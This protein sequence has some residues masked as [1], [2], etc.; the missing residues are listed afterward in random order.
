MKADSTAGIGAPS[1]GRP[2][3]LMELEDRTLFSATPL[4]TA[5]VGTT[6]QNAN[7]SAN[8]QR[9]SPPPNNHGVD[10]VLIDNNLANSKQLAQAVLPGDKVWLYDSVHE[11]A[12]QV[13]SEVE[14]WAKSNGERIEDLAILSHGVGGGFELGN[15]WITARSLLQTSA[16]WQ[17]LGSVLA[18]RANIELFGCDVAAPGSTGQALINELANLTGAEVL[19][20]TNTTGAGGDWNL[21]AESAGAT[22][23]PASS[24]EGPFDYA[25]LEEYKST[26]AALQVTNTNDSGTGSFRQAILDADASSGPSTIVFDLSTSD[27]NYNSSTGVWTIS[28]ASALPLITQPITIDATTQPGYAGSPLVVLTGASAGSGANGINLAS[29]SD[30]STVKGLVI[31]GF[32]GVGIQVTSAN[33]TIQGDYIGTNAAGAAMVGNGS[34]GIEINSNNNLVG[35]TTAADR[36]IISGNFCG[37]FLLGNDNQIEGNYIG[38]DVTGTVALANPRE[39]IELYGGTGNVIGG[40]VA[41]AGN[42]ISGNGQFGVWEYGGGGVTADN[43]VIEGNLIGTDAAG[44]AALGNGSG[45]I[46]ITDGSGNTIGGTSVATR[47]VISG[48]IGCG[49]YLQTANA[50]DTLIEGNYIGVDA[51]GTTALANSSYG[52][53]VGPRATNNV[54]GGSAPG[55][56]NVIS[57]NLNAGVLFEVGSSGSIQGNYIGTNAAGTAPISGNGA[58]IYLATS[59][60]LVGG[61]AAGDGNLISGSN[62]NGVD[63][64]GAVQNDSILGNSISA[65]AG[66][67]IDLGNDGVTPNH[68]GIALLS[69]NGLQ[70]F[71]VLSNVQTTGVE[72]TFTGSL[73]S[74]ILTTYRIEL[75]SNS[76]GDPS[77]YG[78]GTTYLGSTSVTTNLVGN[79]NFTAALPVTI[80]A[81]EV[82]S[83]T[84]TADLGNGNYGGTSEF[85][86]D[87]VAI[88]NQ[89]PVNTVPSAQTVNGTATLVFS[90]GNGNQISIADSD[91]NGNPEQIALSVG[92]GTLTL[93]GTAGL[94]FTNG[95]NGSAAMTVQGTLANINAALNGLTYTAPSNLTNNSSDALNL[96][97]NDLGNS[98]VGGPQTASNTVNIT[99]NHLDITPV[100]TVPAA[101][102]VNGNATLV[103]SSGNGNQISVNDADAN[104]N[105]EQV[106]LSV[107][108]GTLTLNGTIGLTFT[109]GSNGSAMLTVQG[110]LANIN[111]ALSGLTYTPPPNLTNSSSD[112]LNVITNDLGNTGVGGPLSASGTVNIT[113]NHIDTAPVNTVPANQSTEQNV[114]LVFSG[115]N[116]NPISI[117]DK[118]AN[119]APEQMTLSATNGTLTL[120]GTSGLT[121]TGGANGGATMTFQ[122]TIANINNALNGLAFTPTADYAGAASLQVV[123][124]DLGNTGIGGPQ[125]ATNATNITINNATPTLTVPSPQLSM[126]VGLVF[127]STNGNPI[128]VGS[129]GGSVS[130]LQVTLTTT[131]GTVTLAGTSGLSFTSGNGLNNTATTFSGTIAAINAALNGMVFRASAVNDGLTVTATNVAAGNN[132][133]SV[134]ATVPIQQAPLIPPAP[135]PPNPTP[136]PLPP[137]PVVPGPIVPAPATPVV[138]PPVPPSTPSSN[139]EHP[140]TVLPTLPQAPA[141]M[142]TMRFTV[143]ASFTEFA[144]AQVSLRA[145][146]NMRNSRIFDGFA[147]STANVFWEDLDSVRDQLLSRM[148][149]H[150]FVI[151]SAL[152]VSTGLTVGYVMWMLRGGMLLSS[153]IAQ[154]PAWSLIDPLVVL[155]RADDWEDEKNRD[156][157]KES[158]EMIFDASASASPQNARMPA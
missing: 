69:P 152:T 27:P 112:T 73:S 63:V 156:E 58:G 129:S 93:S 99:L 154:I 76:T 78:Q 75:F 10:V 102:T 146:G 4:S 128:I 31:D 144:M 157:N 70:N 142:T 23:P 124:N 67:G 44:T 158:L 81:G 148:P 108:G 89:P 35:G 83:A 62:V 86:Q 137:H 90:G 92:S 88:G 52:I 126:N 46:E 20:S 153:L 1:R 94:T 18:A 125:I 77:G 60:I 7:A 151:G 48:N 12:S 136:A 49:V 104:G 56:G 34:Y 100:N 110:T 65:N 141:R 149:S 43:T 114:P 14:T 138:P 41:G 140:T 132:P 59:N 80:T 54:V 15:Q 21:E 39:G 155:S 111:N 24:V 116:G 143:E 139:I 134:T 6:N 147:S 64:V 150:A 33:N 38:V 28:P 66:L 82:I 55:Q 127:S 103:F 50:T 29:G 16:A 51:T 107:G 87:L 79:A 53:D 95:S 96:V 106:T 131:N 30:G 105:P 120:G 25:V 26:L 123:T 45:G 37:V 97:T 32:S 3:D 101:Q 74:S 8:L 145:G 115:A 36:N 19:A 57:G 109:A 22:S 113:I 47:N 42:V 5:A 40:A 72:T 91:S 11:S 9:P 71:P 133:P 135:S 119:G 117:A 130:T 122:G 68:I 13:L 118:D 84:A 61:T 17:Q 85:A 2:L 121:F 98:G